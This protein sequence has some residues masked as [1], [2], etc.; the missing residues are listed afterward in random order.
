MAP[1]ERVGQ[2]QLD[3]QPANLV[4]EQV[5]QRLDQ[6]EAELLGQAADIVVNLDRRRR[7]VGCAAAFD[8]VGIERSLSQELR[9][10]DRSCLLA[11]DIDEHV[12]DPDSFFLRVDHP[13][14][15]LRETGRRASI[16]LSS[17][18]L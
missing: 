11:K 2:T 13:F 16:T 18:R 10:G 3:A 8:H 17:A 15:R 7:P 9:P 4:L 6:L 5:A 14:E 12:T 1:D